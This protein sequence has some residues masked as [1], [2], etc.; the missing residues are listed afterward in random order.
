MTIYLN[1]NEG[2]KRIRIL[3]LRLKLKLNEE[4]VKFGKIFTII[5]PTHGWHLDAVMPYPHQHIPSREESLEGVKVISYICLN[6]VNLTAA[7]ENST[8]WISQPVNFILMAL[9]W[10]SWQYTADKETIFVLEE[11][12]TYATSIHVIQPRNGSRVSESHIMWLAWYPL[13]PNYLTIILTCDNCSRYGE[14]Q[15]SQPE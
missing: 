12:I 11:Q 3:Q 8:L 9:V 4:V 7:Y 14:L 5:K 13:M 6:Q 2:N 10:L 1:L 15:G